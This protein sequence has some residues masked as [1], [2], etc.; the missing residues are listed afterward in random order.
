VLG[1]ALFDSAVEIEKIYAQ[2]RVLFEQ[3]KKIPDVGLHRG[4]DQESRSLGY[5]TTEPRNEARQQSPKAAKPEE[6]Q[7]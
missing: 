1:I 5:L 7:N 3:E 6:R 4:L 2:S